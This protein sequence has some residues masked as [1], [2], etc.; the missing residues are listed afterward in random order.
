MEEV[1]QSAFSTFGGDG[2]TEPAYV[3]QRRQPDQLRLGEDV[4]ERTRRVECGDDKIVAFLSDGTATAGGAVGAQIT[5]AQG[6][7]S[8]TS[9][10]PLGLSPR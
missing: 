6:S 2:R 9:P 7:G 5:Q 10:S 1:L 8:R 4:G 3:P